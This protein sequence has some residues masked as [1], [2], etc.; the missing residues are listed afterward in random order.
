MQNLNEL[1]ATT[2]FY[3]VKVNTTTV[4]IFHH[5][6]RRQ[7]VQYDSKLMNREGLLN[8]VHI[9][10]SHDEIKITVRSCLLTDE[11]IDPPTA[12]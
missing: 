10:Q 9:L 12:I 6:P 5:K 4:S 2:L 8:M 1:P 11:G 7:L 3:C